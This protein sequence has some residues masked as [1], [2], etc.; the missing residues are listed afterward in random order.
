MAVAGAGGPKSLHPPTTADSNGASTANV[1]S[2]VADGVD[3]EHSKSIVESVQL[4]AFG[5]F[6]SNFA[7]YKCI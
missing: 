5:V 3:T 4:S 7:L 1:A 6:Y 2:A